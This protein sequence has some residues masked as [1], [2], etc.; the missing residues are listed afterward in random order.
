MGKGNKANVTANTKP[1]TTLNGA[2][3]RSVSYTHLDVY[4]RQGIN[5]PL[6][7]SVGR[8][9]DAASALL[10]ICTEPLYEGE[11]AILLGSAVLPDG[12]PADAAASRG[13]GSRGDAEG[14]RTE[15]RVASAI[16]TTSGLSLIHI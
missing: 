5:T 1:G 2:G 15:V 3:F 9:F 16:P 6:T 11:P 10:G 13:T 7:S 12:G 14:S 8:L 4:K